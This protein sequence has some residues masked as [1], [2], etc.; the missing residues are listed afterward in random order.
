MRL[1][2]DDGVVF[3]CFLR[4]EPDSNSRSEAKTKNSR[5]QDK[6]LTLTNKST[7]DKCIV[8]KSTA[9]KCIVDKSTADKCIVDKSTA[10]K[11]LR[12]SVA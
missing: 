1:G 5:E 3:Q 4:V 11:E 12:V 8:D 6:C 2:Y 9:D 10:D 7:A